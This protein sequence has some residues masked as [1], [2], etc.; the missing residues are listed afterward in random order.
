MKPDEMPDDKPED[1]YYIDENGVY[2][3]GQWFDKPMDDG[4]KP[5]NGVAYLTEDGEY[6]GYQEYKDGYA[7]GVRVTFFF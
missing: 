1:A 2:Q 6:C 5:Y 3:Y 4:G 7:T